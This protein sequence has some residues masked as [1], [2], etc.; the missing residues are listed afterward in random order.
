MRA[1]RSDEITSVCEASSTCIWE[2]V[3]EQKFLKIVVENFRQRNKYLIFNCERSEVLKS[4][5]YA[6]LLPHAYGKPIGRQKFLKLV[7]E[8]FCQRNFYFI[9]NFKFKSVMNRF[10]PV[11][12][13]LVRQDALCQTLQKAISQLLLNLRN[14]TLAQF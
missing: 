12:P 8:N 2:A 10:D 4:R 6:K 5:A 9:F 11:R 3:W 14:L 7:V 13:D 1:K